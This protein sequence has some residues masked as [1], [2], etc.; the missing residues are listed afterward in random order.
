MK[1]KNHTNNLTPVSHGRQIQDGGHCE[2][3]HHSLEQQGR[4]WNERNVKN[5]IFITTEHNCL[6]E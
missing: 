5:R 3:R 2:R 6:P 4:R 1:E